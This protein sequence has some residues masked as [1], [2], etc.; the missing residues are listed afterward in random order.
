MTAW[1]KWVSEWGP[2]I[3]K[4]VEIEQ[5]TGR[6]PDALLN[7]P[8]AY[9]AEKELVIAF[10]HLT[11]KR[12]VGMALG[13][14]PMSEIVAYIQL[15]GAPMIPQDIFVELLEIMDEAYLERQAARGNS[16][17]S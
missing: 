9:G 5:A 17:S 2:K 10:N 4:L 8:T 13:R 6:T 14:I 12:P 1:V 16:N 3:R 7:V 15:F 11:H